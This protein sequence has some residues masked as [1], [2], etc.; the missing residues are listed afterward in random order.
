MVGIYNTD[1]RKNSVFSREISTINDEINFTEY[2]AIL[3]ARYESVDG[4]FAFELTNE[5]GG[6]IL[7]ETTMILKINAVQ[8]KLFEEKR[9]FYNLDL[10]KK[11]SL[12]E[13]IPFFQGF[14]NISKEV[15]NKSIG[16]GV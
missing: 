16:E 9:C 5:N 7:S 13:P 3:T 15:A 2:N 4:E 14:I 6:I 10:I 8:N 1:M 11:D 12:E